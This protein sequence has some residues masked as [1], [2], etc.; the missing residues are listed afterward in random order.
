MGSDRD[1]GAWALRIA[2]QLC[3]AG[4][5]LALLASAASMTVQADEGGAQTA[6]PIKHVL[7]II[8]E[9][10]SFDHVFATYVPVQGQRVANLLSKGI[11]R[12]DGTPG[13]SFDRAVQKS[14]R[15]A[16]GIYRLSPPHQRPYAV[17]PAPLAGGQ[18]TP[19]ITSVTRGRE[20][21][22]G[23]APE[24]YQYLVTGGT[25]L[26]S[27]LPDTRIAHVESLP[28]G[29]FQLTSS[30]LPYDAFTQ[31]PVHRFYQ[32]WQQLDCS[33]AQAT[34]TNPSGCRSDL[35]PWVEVTVGSGSNGESQAA[36]FNE[37]STHEGSTSMGFYNVQQ[38]DAPYL[39]WLADHYAMSDNFHQGVLGGTGANHIMLGTGDAIWFSDA[40][41]H[42][43]VPPHRQL[44]AAGTANAGTV[45]EIEDP[46]PQPGTNNYYR[47]D[48]YGGGSQG[49]PSYGGGTYSNCS[50]PRQPGVGPVRNYLASLARPVRANCEAGHYYA[51]NN[52]NPGYFG[53]GANAY[54]DQNEKNTVFTV[55][56][57][58]LRNIG[59][60]LEEKGI[61][62][63]YFGDQ[64][65][66]YLEDKYQTSADGADNYCGICNFLQ[67]S[68]SIM[69][70]PGRRA[71]H[72]RD[73]LD[74][75]AQIEGGNLPAVSFVKPSGI[76]DGHPA[77]SK[78]NLFEG[79]AKKI[80]DLVRA[81]AALAKDTVI[82]VTFDEGGGYYDSGYVQP[83]DFF[84]DGT[85]VPLIAVSTY[86]NPGHI[87]HDYTDHAS[88]LKFIERNWHLKPLTGRSRDNLPNP[89]YGAHG[90]Y[91]PDNSPA[92]GD[93]FDLFN[94]GAK[95]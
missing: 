94:F 7:V 26:K 33:A 36:D 11:V 89:V 59:D 82:F 91:A 63:A 54:A 52:Y 38:G 2:G 3:N 21:E 5:C 51:L 88:L 35:F 93:L 85:R 50:D 77:S 78:L 44:V 6:S 90:R 15:N 60:A 22:N 47:Q 55:P 37:R 34:R 23:L 25:G 24:D 79:F 45:D 70:D 19:E 29:P 84:G 14:A 73:T 72:I 87:S 56:P 43:A 69:G 18:T 17:L 27:G 48:G 95:P 65:N 80:V 30:T 75:Y 31:S 53:D 46:N 39:K 76:V 58:T 4:K 67:Y 66:R 64:W 13:P 10:R 42:P 81:Q 8:G 71:A 62:Y 41:G 74:L 9:N 68:T 61:S 40:E 20:L 92:I 28:P 49:K 83:V 1:C 32:M 86:T 12:A 16:D 57:S